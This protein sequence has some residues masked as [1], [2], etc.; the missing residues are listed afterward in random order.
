MATDE[1]TTAIKRNYESEKDYLS[2]VKT[3][4]LTEKAALQAKYNET[5]AQSNRLNAEY[6]SY[7]GNTGS[8][9]QAKQAYL[10][11]LNELEVKKAS[12]INYKDI[13]DEESVKADLQVYYKSIP[14]EDRGDITMDAFVAAHLDDAVQETYYALL[15]SSNPGSILPT[16]LVNSTETTPE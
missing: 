13:I 1:H 12:I 2:Q 8:I 3:D 16:H 14:L 6:E 15:A 5:I 7:I 11:K 10:N 9:A 4:L